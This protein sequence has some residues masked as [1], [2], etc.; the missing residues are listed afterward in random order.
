M[1]LYCELMLE[2]CAPFCGQ[3]DASNRWIVLGKGT[4][5]DGLARIYNRS[6]SQDQG[7]PALDGRRVVGAMIIKHM[8]VLDD[9]GTMDTIKEDPYLQCFCGLSAFSY[10][11]IFDASSLVTLRKRMGPAAF[12]LMDGA[13][14]ARVKK[15]A[16]AKK[17][18]PDGQQPARKSNV[19][20]LPTAAAATPVVEKPTHKGMLNIDD[21]V[22]PQQIIYPPT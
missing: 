7:R 8:L 12:D 16:A 4:P 17:A 9:H 11:P 2:S 22:A 1:D 21:T 14:M 18:P 3:L 15:T 20:D 19:Q 10:E 5:W 13:I 6:L